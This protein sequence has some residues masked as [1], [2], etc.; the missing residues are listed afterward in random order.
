MAGS[1][2]PP[3]PRELVVSRLLL[4][5]TVVNVPK[6]GTQ[7]SY[8]MALNGSLRALVDNAELEWLPEPARPSV[9][10]LLGGP[11]WVVG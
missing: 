10:E 1:V 6:P 8:V 9:W 7:R 4:E 3:V 5:G 2:S 11:G